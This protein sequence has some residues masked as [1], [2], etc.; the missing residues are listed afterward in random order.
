M[1]TRVRTR[2][3]T[4][5]RSGLDNGAEPAWDVALLFPRQG[6]WTE[7][8]YLALDS[9]GAYPLIELSN[10]RLEVLPMP[11]QTHQLIAAYLFQLLKA[12][13]DQY[14]PG[15]V[16]FTGMRIR[17]SKDPRPTIRDPDIVYMKAEHARRR[18]E[19]YWDGADL[20]ME[21]VSPGQDNR[22]RDLKT[23]RT[24]YAQ[25]RIPEYWIVDPKER[26]IRVLVLRGK[27]YRRYGEFVPGEE[28]EGL[29]LPGFRVSVEAAVHPPGS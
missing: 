26:C 15:T 4:A 11:N 8:N 29:L 21:I 7:E 5:K 10:G 16:L 9:H 22:E 13:A 24:E 14:A 1:S 3:K 18:H 12:F 27:A 25:A 17:L 2:A 28:A 20:V 23:K 19:Q 6:A